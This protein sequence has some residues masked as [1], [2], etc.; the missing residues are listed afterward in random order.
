MTFELSD[1]FD[2]RLVLKVRYQ[3]GSAKDIAMVPRE[4]VEAFL[5]ALNATRMAYMDD[6]GRSGV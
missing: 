3:D 1:V 2:G 5:E 6:L 4:N